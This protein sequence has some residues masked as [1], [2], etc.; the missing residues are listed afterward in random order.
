MMPFLAKTYR[1]TG[2]WESSANS[3]RR[4]TELRPNDGRAYHYLG[5]SL[6]QINRFEE[7]IIALKTA[8]ELGQWTRH[9]SRMIAEAYYLNGDRENAFN[10]IEET[11]SISEDAGYSKSQTKHFLLMNRTIKQLEHDESFQERFAQ[12]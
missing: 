1:G 7:A 2:D 10:W 9:T 4:I 6:V 5:M 3:Y 11:I 8:F 12:N